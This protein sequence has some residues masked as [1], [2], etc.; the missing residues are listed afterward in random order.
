MCCIF[1]FSSITCIQNCAL[2][3]A[4]AS[5]R[6]VSSPHTRAARRS[7]HTDGSHPALSPSTPL[8]EVLSF[9]CAT[10]SVRPEHN[11]RWGARDYPPQHPNTSWANIVSRPS[12]R[13]PFRSSNPE[14]Q[15]A[16]C[17]SLVTSYTYTDT[18]VAPHDGRLGLLHL[19]TGTRHY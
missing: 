6:S 9:R 11:G 8:D 17:C 13:Q 18:Y 1:K 10:T 12:I 15:T 16:T 7:L 4:R 2:R 5:Q 19:D 3:L 14:S